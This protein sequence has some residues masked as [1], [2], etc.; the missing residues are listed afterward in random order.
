[1]SVAHKKSKE[2]SN[3]NPQDI[4]ELGREAAFTCLTLAAPI[5]AIGLVAGIVIGII[6][7]M[8]H[9]QDQTAALVPKIVLIS[10]TFMFCLPWLTE[11][12]LEYS[13]GLFEKPVF[14]MGATA[15]RSPGDAE[16]RES[17]YTLPELPGA[18]AQDET[19][20]RP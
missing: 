5:L 14:A 18:M 19:L 6:Q 4:V 9:V 10:L 16:T 13:K 11:V 12:I 1:M 17:W 8:T 2:E 20:R 15:E 3:M 7:S